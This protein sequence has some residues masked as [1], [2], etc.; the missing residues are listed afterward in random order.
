MARKSLSVAF[1]AA[2]LLL[3][4]APAHAQETPPMPPEQ[5]VAEPLGGVYFYLDAELVSVPR[6]IAGGGQMVE[7]GLLELLQGPNEEERADGY[8]TYIPEGV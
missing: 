7:F 4:C 3:L 8:V 2:L 1:L 5:E 6:D